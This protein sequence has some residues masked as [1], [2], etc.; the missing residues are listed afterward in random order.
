MELAVT[1][2][3]LM[4]GVEAVNTLLTM[5]PNGVAPRAAMTMTI[6][7][8]VRAIQPHV[9]NYN[10]AL[11]AARAKYKAAPAEVRQRE[12]DAEIKEAR[13]LT[14]TLPIGK[15]SLAK[16]DAEGIHLT[17]QELLA[18]DWLLLE[19]VNPEFVPEEAK[20]N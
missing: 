18:L 13:A 6:G 14:V 1:V 11:D 8:V 3:K 9:D 20:T 15:I 16:L 10:A 17:A 2:G 12:F 5:K 4:D 19:D 7:A